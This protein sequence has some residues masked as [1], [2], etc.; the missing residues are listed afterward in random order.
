[1]RKK[2][3]MLWA[4][5]AAV[6]CL[7]GCDLLPTEEM[8]KTAP[9]IQSYVRPT[10]PTDTVQRETLI[11]QKAVSCRYVP[12][13]TLG[14]SFSLAGEYVD[15]TFVQAGDL[16]QKGQLLAQ[17]RLDNI[18]ERI[19]QTRDTIEEN[20]LRLAH[21]TSLE[22]IALRRC[23]VETAHLTEME[24]Q[25]KRRAVMDDYKDRRANLENTLALN[26]IT[27]SSLEKE[28]EERQ[29]IAPFDGAVT[30]V[31]QFNAGAMSVFGE[32]VI[33]LAD[34]TL[35]LFRAETDLWHYF[36]PGDEY[37][38]MVGKIPYAAVV[39]K[40]EDLGLEV[41]EK[42]EGKRAYVYFVLKELSFELED[43][44]TGKI[45][46]TLDT[47]ENVLTVPSNAVTFANGQA[48]VYYLD[49]NGMKAYKPVEPGVT[50]NKRTEIISGLSEG[51]SIIVK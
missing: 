22:E 20:Q 9:I 7:T 43:G 40:E 46:L 16:V 49:E 44:D 15:E 41:Q 25:E 37:Q 51:E 1:M 19:A 34:A 21:L 11:S 30:Y 5:L 50:I 3:L 8:P 45:T 13:Q 6:G 26:R 17:L 35:S 2:Y 47:R 29:I 14:L 32:R 18:Q 31:R 33:T 28:L 36:V 23:E 38:I 4:I 12:L 10:Y 27:L 39:A 42:V 48:I 24:Q